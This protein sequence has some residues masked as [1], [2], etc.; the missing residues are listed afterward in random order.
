MV[1]KQPLLKVLKYVIHLFVLGIA[2][3]AFNL[4]FP[5]PFN[6]KSINVLFRLI[7]FYKHS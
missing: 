4:W 1:Y 6:Y 5:H 7:K 2:E 3:T